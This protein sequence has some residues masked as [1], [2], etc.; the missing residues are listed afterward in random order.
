M[1][2]L[3]SVHYL[4]SIELEIVM[5]GDFKR[6]YRSM[7]RKAANGDMNGQPEVIPVPI[8]DSGALVIEKLK[9]AF[10]GTFDFNMLVFGDNAVIIAFLE[11]MVDKNLISEAVIP[12]IQAVVDETGARELSQKKVSFI[13]NRLNSM[14]VNKELTNFDD[15][16]NSILSGETMIFLGGAT[17]A[18]SLS[19]QKFEKRSIEE[20][21]SEAVTR[22]SREAFTEVL[23]TNVSMIRRR[24]K[25][26]CL[27]FEKT[28]IG[29]QTKTDVVM[30]YI[31]GLANQ[32]IIDEVRKR[33]NNINTEAILESGYIEEYITDSPF[34]IF[35]LAFNSERPDT[36]S[37]KLLEGRIA[38][39][40]DGTPVVLTVPCLFIDY[41]QFGE[42]YNNRFIF[43]SIIRPIRLIAFL[44]S[45][46]APAYFIA[47]LCF[48]PNVIPFKLLVTVAKSLEGVPLSPLI[49]MLILTV[50]FEVIKE[51][52][53]RMSRGFG[54]SLSIVGGLIVGQAAVQAGIFS[55]PAVVA[56][57]ATSISA[58]IISK[59][60][61]TVIIIRVMCMIAANILGILGIVLCSTVFLAHA[62]SLKSFGVPF[63][64]PIVPMSGTDMKDTFI[65][66]PFWVMFQKPETI[67][68]RYVQKYNEKK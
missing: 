65:R 9:R 7:R 47:F 21:D 45:T 39:L 28:V 16:V 64:S 57:A 60:D 35:P 8:P 15:C 10:N 23:V 56:I 37:G 63:L 43:S 34:S 17:T 24:I 32:E 22:G 62:C 11:G 44:M 27:I 48:H 59:L 36:V 13:G 5:L 38:I 25:D 67:T 55:A 20:S 40:C 31:K 50:L 6:F 12:P 29:R 53:L 30:C 52:G 58:F 61:A 18:L 54:Q 33:L 68:R 1:F 42:D 49:E 66:M 41:L 19:L 26:S 14:C 51:S 46:M 4:P 2:I 3:I